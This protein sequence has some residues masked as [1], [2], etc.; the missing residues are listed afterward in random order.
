MSENQNK[1]KK[2]AA[3]KDNASKPTK[4][5]NVFADYVMMLVAPCVMA[6]YYNGQ[7]AVKTLLAAIVAAVLSDF[8]ASIIFY[9]KYTVSDL[10]ALYT[11]AAIA[12]MLPAGVAFHV[13]VTASVF[14]VLAVKIPLGGGK[15]SPFVPA[16]AG[17]AFA[18]VCF[19]QEVFTF[20]PLETS[21]LAVNGVSLA[22]LLDSGSSPNLNMLNV[23]D[24]ILGNVSGPMG[25]GCALVMLGCSTYILFRRPR[26]IFATIG[27]VAA[28]AVSALLFPRVQTGAAASVFFELCSGSLLFAAVFF[29]TDPATSPDKS[30]P[31]LGYGVLGG[32]LCMLMRYFGVYEEGVCFAVLMANA[33]WPVVRTVFNKV[34]RF[35]DSHLG[36]RKTKEVA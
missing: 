33:A 14:A 32:V 10:T 24:V 11:G 12:L 20:A 8:I 27:F 35:I 16:A 19:P 25:T 9:K 36:A 23:F 4:V 5:R 15:K 13:P 17:F 26:A 18:S 31:A 6:W 7:A 21:G 3:K 1:T 28:C 2:P 22:A 30:L 29:M 34:L